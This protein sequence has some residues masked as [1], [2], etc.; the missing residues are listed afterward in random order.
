MSIDPD[1]INFRSVKTF[2]NRHRMFLLASIIALAAVYIRFSPAENMDYLQ[3]MDSYIIYRF[4]QHIAL[5][6]SFP[7]L[8]FFRY[9][10]YAFPTYAE[11]M[12]SFYIPAILYW[13]GPFLFLDYLTWAQLFPPLMG[14]L[15]VIAIYFIGKEAFDPLTGVSAAFFLATIAGVMHRS[16]AGFFQKDPI[17]AAFM[18]VSIYFFIRAWK[19]DDWYSGIGAG[20]TLGVAT[21]SWGG[22]S[23]LW[24]LYALTVGVMLWINEDIRKLVTA[25]TPT[26]LIGAF[27]AASLNHDRFWLTDLDFL[28]NLAVLL[29]L[30]SR[31]LLEEL[32]LVKENYLPYYIPSVSIFGLVMAA[33]SPLYSQT[34]ANMFIRM[35]RRVTRQQSDSDVIGGT[36][37]ENTPV[38]LGELSSQLGSVGVSQVQMFVSDP[39]A[40]IISPFTAIGGLISN[41]NGPWPLAFIGIVF[42]STSILFMVLRK[43]EFVEETINERIFYRVLAA[44]LVVWIGSFSLVFDD[45][46]PGATLIAVGPAVFALAGSLGILYSLEEFRDIDIEIKWYQIILVLWAVSNIL[47]AS[48][49][50]RLVFLASYPTAFM[51]GYMFAK[52]VRRI[53]DLGPESVRYLSVG[54]G[55]L[56]IDITLI[57][58]LL[59]SGI[60]II[61]AVVAVAILNGLGY[62]IAGGIESRHHLNSN[63][64]STGLLAIMVI[65]TI[66]VNFGSGY[67][68]ANSLQESPDELWMENLDYLNEEADEDA[69]V[70]S[71]WDY[72]YHFQSVGRT[73]T[74]ADGGNLGYYTDE[75]RIPYTIADFF[76]SENPEEHEEL[77]K[78]HS[79]DYLV[80]DETMLGKYSAVSQIAERDNENFRSM[81]QLESPS[82]IQEGVTEIDNRTMV[83]FSGQGINVY[84]P[85]DNSEGSAEITSAPIFESPEFRGEID[86]VLTDDGVQEFDGDGIELDGFGEVCAAQ[87]PYFNVD[88][89][90]AFGQQGFGMPARLVLVPKDIKDHTMVRLYLMDGYDIDFLESA[91]DAS[92]D[93]IK[94]WEVDYD[95]L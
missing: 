22:S 20:A 14:G 3:A 32:E 54:S 38:T 43:L 8:D 9:F 69:V 73:A 52:V 56:L 81:I 1:D 66:L 37:A 93:Y 90:L 86:C 79:V 70:L 51:A 74:V 89:A 2:L 40:S 39:Y 18:L 33:L 63:Y 10:P 24:L 12:G 4:S 26:I 85:V 48:A 44:V 31:Y 53:R 91:P 94:T 34:L 62:I 92:N 87:N 61:P 59:I 50:S 65:V 83:E 95:E 19:R 46:T 27:L 68:A 60:G 42:L 72:G 64:L 47:A 71:W 77:F 36:V 16:G 21:I 57:V 13:L 35:V 28:A 7:A 45:P 11:N 5:D 58:G 29:L 23:M 25:Y 17:S 55:V 49:Q 88:R 76:T 75:D 78:K 30:W 41:I 15:S 82:N 84:T 6:W 80:L 67:S